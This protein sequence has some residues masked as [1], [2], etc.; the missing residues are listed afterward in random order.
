VSRAPKPSGST[1]SGHGDGEAIPAAGE[2][3]VRYTSGLLRLLLRAYAK[4]GRPPPMLC[5]CV[6]LPVCAAPTI[7]CDGNISQDL[8]WEAYVQRAGT[9]HARN[10]EFAGALPRLQRHVL[11]LIQEAKDL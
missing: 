9:S 3:S 8:A 10:C 11:T 5:A 4:R 6:P 1:R 7:T 2:R